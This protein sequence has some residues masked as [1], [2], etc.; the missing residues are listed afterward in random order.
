MTAFAD[1]GA[2]VRDIMLTP[3]PLAGGNVRRG[4]RVPVP[5]NVAEA[6]DVHVQ[7]STGDNAQL[8]GA[9]LQWETLVGIDL[10]ARAAAAGDGEAAIDPL[11]QA[12]FAR[13]NNTPAPAGAIAWALQPAI[14][15]DVDEADQTLVQASLALRI[16]HFTT[17]DLAAA[18]V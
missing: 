7:R 12:V 4:R 5:A 16:T 11:L 10:Y 15:W 1:L 8:D 13:I 2:A 6:I 9:L 3:T 18:A 14:Q 17:T